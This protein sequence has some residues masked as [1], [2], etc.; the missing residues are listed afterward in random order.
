VRIRQAGRRGLRPARRAGDDHYVRVLVVGGA[1]Y[2]PSLFLPALAGRYQVRILDPRRPSLPVEQLPV[3][4]VPG[5]ATDYPTVRAAMTGVDLV[6]HAATGDHDAAAPGYLASLHAGNVTS[7]HLTLLAADDAGVRHAVH[8]SSMSVY[9]ELTARRLDEAVPADATD[10]Y[11]LT[12]R[13]GEEVCRAVSD[14]CTMTVNVLRLAYP[15]ADALWPA[16]GWRQPP[17]VPVAADGTPIHATAGSDVARA[18]LA[19]LEHRN[20]F[21]VFIITGDRS[22]RLW[23]TAKARRELGWAPRFTTDP[24]GTAAPVRSAT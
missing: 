22:A 15:T 16:W 8:I 9:H 6:I 3:E 10:P 18:V 24:A 5:D 20:G 7:V 14:R 12:K 1:G 23:S 21:Q 13:L 2:A 11:G 19:A 4:H 17:S